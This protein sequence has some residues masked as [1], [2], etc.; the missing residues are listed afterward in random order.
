[1]LA[2]YVMDHWLSDFAYHTELSWNIF[3][4][5]GVIATGVAL[6]TVSFQS[7]KA[8]LTNPVKSLKT[9]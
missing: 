1:M 9:E 5:A 3:L 8:A 4:L 7:M 6:L 2:W